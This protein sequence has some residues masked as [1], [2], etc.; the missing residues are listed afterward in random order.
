MER[1]TI[2]IAETNK[3]Q[4]KFIKDALIRNK[5][6]IYIF[7]TEPLNSE[8]MRNAILELKPDIVI[9]NERKRDKPA[10]DVIREIQRDKTIKQPIFILLSGYERD[11]I[12]YILNK[13]NIIAHLISKPYDY[14]ELANYIKAI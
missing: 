7:E 2:L 6:N 11:S 10:T 4:D 13:D 3:P 9:T 14:D 8:E 1:K 5:V 12:K